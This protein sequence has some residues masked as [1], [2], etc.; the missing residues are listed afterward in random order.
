[1]ATYAYD[2]EWREE[3]ERLAGIERLWDPGSRS[4]LERLGVGPG[5]RCLEVGA[6][7]GAMSEWLA[8]RADHVVAADISTRFLQAIERP[9]VEVL[10]VDVLAGGLPARAFDLVYSRLVAE[11]LGADAVIRMAAAVRPGGLLLLEDFDFVASTVDPPDEAF[12]RAVTGVCSFMAVGGFDP[13]FG[14]RLPNLLRAAGLEGVEAE[15]RTRLARGGTD[16]VAFYRLSL[17]ALRERAAEAGLL[18]PA[19]AGRALELL[20]DPQRVFG[21]PLVVAAWGRRPAA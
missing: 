11:H 18:A 15:G 6:G 8:G 14:R 7:G 21:S 17:L 16:D 10:E 4:L 5:W 13:Y 12:P 19:D 3:R 2:P 20:G 1:M 9:N